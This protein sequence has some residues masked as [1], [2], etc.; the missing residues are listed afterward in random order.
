MQ[1]LSEHARFLN[2][3]TRFV[4]HD[5]ATRFLSLFQDQASQMVEGFRLFAVRKQGEVPLKHRLNKANYRDSGLIRRSTV[6]F[7]AVSVSE[8]CRLQFSREICRVN[9]VI[10]AESI[11][12][13]GV[14][15]TEGR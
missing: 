14:G 8:F 12:R 5:E 2:A 10:C 3:A 15:F 4:C 7:G 9:F 11:S 6:C 1:K 13:D